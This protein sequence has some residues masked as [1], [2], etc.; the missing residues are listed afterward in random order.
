MTNDHFINIYRN[1]GGTYHELIQVEDTD[2]NLLPALQSICSF[3]HKQILDLATG[4]GRIPLLLP[5]HSITALDLHSSMLEE[6]HKQKIA[7][8][9]NWTI[10]QGDMRYLPFPSSQF[11]IVTIGW[12][13]GHFLSWYSSNWKEQ[14]HLVL[15]QVNRVLTLKGSIIILET[16][17]TGSLIPAPPSTALAS[18]YHW[19][20]TE[21]HFQR[22]QVQTDYQ[23]N[24]LEDA[25]HYSQFFFGEDL[26]HKIRLNQWT[27]LPEWTGIWYKHKTGG[28]SV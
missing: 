7:A 24:S 26:A 27:R 19:L 10:T 16:L 9:G 6:N 1:A 23:F 11:D 5:Q 28:K 21:L 25:I 15:E 4:T 12:G 3:D 14:I 18:Y 20:E 22:I 17:T 8:N 2:Q 13:L